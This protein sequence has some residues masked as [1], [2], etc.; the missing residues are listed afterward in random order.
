MKATK[1]RHG[2]GRFKAHAIVLLFLHSYAP[3]RVA[4]LFGVT[5]DE[6]YAC[7]RRNGRAQR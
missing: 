5:V 4:R 3:K 2:L 1:R 6:V 7:I